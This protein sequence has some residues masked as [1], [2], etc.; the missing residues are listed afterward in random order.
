LDGNLAELWDNNHDGEPHVNG[1]IMVDGETY[2]TR[3]VE[4]ILTGDKASTA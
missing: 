4:W 2:T 1:T 3:G